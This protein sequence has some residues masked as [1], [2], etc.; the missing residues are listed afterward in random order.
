MT[1][2]AQASATNNGY[3]MSCELRS[4][5][6]RYLE[7]QFRLPEA[8]RATEPLLRELLRN[9]LKRGKVDVTLKLELAPASQALQL[10]N[11]LLTQLVGAAKDVQDQ[12]PDATAPSALDLLRWPGMLEESHVDQE[13]AT[14]SATELFEMALERL[15]DA[16]A[17][18]GHRLQALLLQQLTTVEGIVDD[19][20]PQSENIMRLQQQRLHLRL[21][22]LEIKAD[23]ARLEQEVALLAQRSD[24]REELDRLMIH[25][26]EAR[27]L[28]NEPGPHGRRL[29]FLSQEL[30][31]EANTL[32]AKATQ[33]DVSQKA[34]DLKVVI[35]QIREQVQNVE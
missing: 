1:A 10:N 12:V 33:T 16:R 20:R 19:V 25:V 9:H 8:L 6:H 28:I 21:Q 3:Q 17:S 13:L 18:E 22:E 24:I 31:R 14:Q 4:V 32:G 11:T 26:A 15:I 5:N 7:P 35:E 2:F 23:P 29:D 34:I 30:N 27:K